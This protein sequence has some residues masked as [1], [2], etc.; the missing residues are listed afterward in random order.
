MSDKK[1][2]SG[3]AGQK[4]GGAQNTSGGKKGGGSK[5]GAKA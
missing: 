4:P 1:S 3:S 2:G 5:S